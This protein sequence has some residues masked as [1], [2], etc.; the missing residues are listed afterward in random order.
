[1]SRSQTSMEKRCSSHPYFTVVVVCVVLTL[2]LLH[3]FV[4]KMMVIIII[5]IRISALSTITLN[6]SLSHLMKVSNHRNDHKTLLLYQIR[7]YFMF[8]MLY[9]LRMNTHTDIYIYNLSNIYIY[10]YILPL[11]AKKSFTDKE[12]D[13]KLSYMFLLFGVS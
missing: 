6:I 2:A 11:S 1:M 12:I 10:I 13:S 5:I 7:K 3:P 9:G 8:Y 4:V